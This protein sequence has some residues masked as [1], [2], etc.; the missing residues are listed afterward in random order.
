MEIM[1]D[2]SAIMA[3]IA[4]EP[5]SN[6]VINC[7]KN[8][9]IISPKMLSFEIANA[10]TR[11]VKKGIIRNSEKI[12]DLINSF[13]KIP[14]KMVEIDLGKSMKIAWDYKIYAYDAFY[15]ETAKRLNLP[16][17]TFDNGMRRIG[18]EIGI[19]ILGG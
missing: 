8:A 13:Q 18:R 6:V 15:L 3:V 14:I 9:T 4:D 16:L 10:L 17:L 12:D 1:L 11:M 2:A 5:E 19:T 7:T